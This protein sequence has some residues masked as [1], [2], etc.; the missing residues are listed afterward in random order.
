MTGSVPA[1]RTVVADRRLLMILD[2]AGDAE[3]AEAAEEAIARF[4]GSL[5]RFDVVV[6][7]E[8]GRRVHGLTKDDFEVYDGEARQQ[9]GEGDTAGHRQAFLE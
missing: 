6:T 8:R 1:L 2:N 5:P 3:Q 9:R 4:G 7:D